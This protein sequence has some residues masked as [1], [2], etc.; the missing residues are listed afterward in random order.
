M[1][2]LVAHR[3]YEVVDTVPPSDEVTNKI[4]KKDVKRQIKQIEKG[5]EPL[6]SLQP[7]LQSTT[8]DRDFDLRVFT[9]YHGKMETT[10]RYV[11]KLGVHYL[12]GDN[13]IPKDSERALECFGSVMYQDKIAAR[14]MADCALKGCGSLKANQKTAEMVYEIAAKKGDKEAQK[15]LKK[16]CRKKVSTTRYRNPRYEAAR[17]VSLPGWKRHK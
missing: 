11:R 3:H 1:L 8:G 2:S 13:P 12:K 6:S 14:M 5:A 7:F 10:P 15:K 16:L 17:T 9:Y 4:S